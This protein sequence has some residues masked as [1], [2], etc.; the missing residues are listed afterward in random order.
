MTKCRNILILDKD[1]HVLC[2]ETSNCCLF[3]E[4]LDRIENSCLDLFSFEKADVN[5]FYSTYFGVVNLSDYS[6]VFEEYRILGRGLKFCPTPPLFDHG[7]VKESIDKFFRNANLFLCFSDENNSQKD[8]ENNS[9]GRFKQPDLKLPAK[10]NP[11]K[12]NML[13][14]TQEILNDRILKYNP[15]RNR[16]RNMSNKEYKI[17]QQLQEMK[18]IVIKK[19]DKGLNVVILNR[20]NY[21]QETMRQLQNKQFYKECSENLTL[22]H[23][24]II[25]ELVTELLEKEFISEQTY[26]FL[27]SGGKRTSVFYILPKIHKNLENPPGRPIVSSIDCPTERISMMLDMILQPLLLTTKSYIKDTPDFLRKLSKEIILEEENFFTLDV[28]SL[29]TNIPL[30]ESL[31]IMEKEFFPRTDCVIPPPYLVKMLELILKCNNFTFNRKHFLQVNGTA[32]GTR[33]A[34]T[35]ANLFMAHIE[36]SYVYTYKDNSKPRIWFRFI[37]DIWG[38]FSGNSISFQNF[39]E[40]LNSIHDTIKFTK[41]FSSIE[42]NFLDVTTYR[43]GQEILSKLYCKPTDSHSYLEFNSCHPPHNKTSIPFSQF[44]RIRRN[45]S[46][47]EDFILY[48]MQLS[49]YFSIRGYYTE[50]VK[51]AFC[52]VNSMN[53]ITTLNAKVQNPE[54]SDKKKIFLI[55]DYNPSLPPIKEWIEEL[56]PILYKRSATRILVDRITIIVYQRPKNLQ[57]L[58]VSSDLPEINW[59][60]SKKKYSIPRCN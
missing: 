60:G 38:I 5:K 37:D 33:V 47:W 35:Y 53:R 24:Q 18:S 14:H 15:S 57:D 45:C 26:T 23:H 51:D 31:Q 52:K 59:F 9:M 3:S 40:H 49:T 19:A 25:Q 20:E 10:F 2:K 39:V 46:K 11:P 55:L 54:N 4:V 58:L 1:F 29:Y 36:E 6:I 17:L 56:W 28:S 27:S 32:M 41:E 12:P 21:I 50:Y 44:L 34:P 13:E 22:K 16:P 42:I 7:V 30:E 8:L 48:G 43:N